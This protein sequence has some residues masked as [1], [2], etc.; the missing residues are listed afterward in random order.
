MQMYIVGL[1]LIENGF[2]AASADKFSAEARADPLEADAD[3][4]ASVH[5]SDPIAHK[6]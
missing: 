3:S 5:L 1:D 4:E 6:T 2:V